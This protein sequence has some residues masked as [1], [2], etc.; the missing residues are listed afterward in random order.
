[1]YTTEMGETKVWLDET[2]EYQNNGS[3][4]I[5]SCR[6]SCIAIGTSY[7]MRSRSEIGE[8]SQLIYPLCKLIFQM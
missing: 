5:T 7:G 6:S 8:E 1:M 4:G 3:L 2:D